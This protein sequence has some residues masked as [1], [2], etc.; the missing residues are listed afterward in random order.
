MS[1]SAVVRRF[2]GEF[3]GKEESVKIN[4]YFSNY[5]QL[6]KICRN[7][8]ASIKVFFNIVSAKYFFGAPNF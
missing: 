3:S 1:P 4:D 5:K 7:I 8:Y 2:G 6:K